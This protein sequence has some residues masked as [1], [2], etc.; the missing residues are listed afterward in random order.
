MLDLGLERPTTYTLEINRA[1]AGK[2]ADRLIEYNS[3][4]E[5]RESIIDD[6][7][8]N[9]SDWHEGYA[10]AKALDT[11][12]RWSIDAE[13]VETL[14]DMYSIR[15]DE[16]RQLEKEWVA[17]TNPPILYAVGD[18]VSFQ[19][20]RDGQVKGPIHSIETDLGRYV[21]DI[22]G[23]GNGGRLVPYENVSAA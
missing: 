14:S 19:C 21:V 13:I 22:Q 18:I 4:T 10:L 20:P 11:Y 15:S 23:T 12:C 8:K 3:F 2:M 7:L 5:S 6:L 16:L 17:Q 9:V 1:A